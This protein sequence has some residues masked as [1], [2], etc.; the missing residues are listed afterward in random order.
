M[1][2]GNRLGGGSRWQKQ[3]VAATWRGWR[4]EEAA[5]A[6]AQ[7]ERGWRRKGQG[8]LRVRVSPPPPR[9]PPL[10]P[11]KAGPVGRRPKFSSPNQK[12]EI[13][14]LILVKFISNSFLSL[15]VEW[16]IGI[17]LTLLVSRES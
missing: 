7:W 12:S 9:R 13:P 10:V 15:K 1:I 6:A 5:G 4:R 3:G 17:S 16:D 11:L 14:Y 8:W 2:K